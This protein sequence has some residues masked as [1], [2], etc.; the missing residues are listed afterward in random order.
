MNP[1]DRLHAG[2]AASSSVWQRIV[3]SEARG[4]HLT[5]SA[6]EV[7]VLAATMREAVDCLTRAEGEELGAA[8]DRTEGIE[9][10]NIATM[11]AGRAQGYRGAAV[12]VRLALGMS[13]KDARPPRVE[14]LIPAWVRSWMGSN[15][16]GLSS[17]TIATVMLGLPFELTMQRG[18]GEA[19]H[20]TGDVG[21]CVRLLDLADQRGVDWRARLGEL[22]ERVPAWAPLVPRWYDIETAYREDEAAQRAWRAAGH[23]RN[24]RRKRGGRLVTG[25]GYVK[26]PPSRCYYLVSV[27]RGCRDPYAGE[28]VPWEREPAPVRP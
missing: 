17:L 9:A 16:T 1:G 3:E 5:L 12:R 21:R 22:V 28:T 4:D 8:L 24:V 7:Q 11:S 14:P 23:D 6:D 13:S 2:E 20:D 25:P 19:P 10:L 15:D 18:R 27:L 26:M